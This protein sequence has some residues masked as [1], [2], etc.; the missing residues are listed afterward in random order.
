MIRLTYQW[1]NPEPW[2]DEEIEV[3]TAEDHVRIAVTDEK[4]LD[5]YNQTFTC[6]VNLPPDQVEELWRVLGQW[7][8]ARR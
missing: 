8:E 4:A 6:A 5:S 3:T 1:T 7:L 2:N